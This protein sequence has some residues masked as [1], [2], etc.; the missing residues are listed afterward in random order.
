MATDELKTFL[1][2]EPRLTVCAAES[3]TTG[4][5][6]ARLT[7]LSGASAFFVGG[8]TAYDLDQ[9]VRHLGVDREAAAAVNCVSAQV[10]REMAVGALA[11]FGAD[12]ALSTTGYAER[13]EADDVREP[14][15]WWGL[16]HRRAGTTAPLVRVGRVVCA[17]MPR[18]RVK[19]VVAD[20]VV[21][22]LLAYLRETRA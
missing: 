22:E 11:L 10:A 7:A 6:Q 2:R 15:A 1:L 9:K 12:L 5:V 19:Q 14:M 18:E 16:A 4:F 13:C 17:G 8:M 3:L 20:V 21:A